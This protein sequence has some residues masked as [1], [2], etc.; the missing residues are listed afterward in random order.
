MFGVLHNGKVKPSSNWIHYF[1]NK[2]SFRT[3]TY[4][5]ALGAE[6]IESFRYLYFDVENSLKTKIVYTDFSKYK[7]LTTKQKQ[8]AMIIKEDKKRIRISPVSGT[9]FFV[10]K[11]IHE[12]PKKFNYQN[13]DLLE[14]SH[15]IQSLV[16]SDFL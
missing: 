4:L 2:L 13:C 3:D 7:R 14:K 9:R 12:R 16:M 5:E 1:F 11:L 15:Q 6:D 10:S 8:F